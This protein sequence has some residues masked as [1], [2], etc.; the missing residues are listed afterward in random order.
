MGNSGKHLPEDATTTGGDTG[1]ALGP[2]G[3]LGSDF[4]TPGAVCSC[5]V[6]QICLV[7]DF[8]SLGEEPR[9]WEGF[10][11]RAD[12]CFRM[13]AQTVKDPGWVSG[14]FQPRVL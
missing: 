14:M 3:A 7:G 1:V 6:G 8:P 5:W 12:S 9:E 11:A 2:N 10:G 4:L 13:E